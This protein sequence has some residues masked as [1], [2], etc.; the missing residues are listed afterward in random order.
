LFDVF[1]EF[2]DFLVVIFNVALVHKTMS[3]SYNVW[4]MV[5]VFFKSIFIFFFVCVYIF[6]AW[7]KWWTAK[8]FGFKNNPNNVEQAHY[9]EEDDHDHN[10]EMILN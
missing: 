5:M 10:F 3:E 4:M 8:R 6:Y 7:R 1:V 9:E 2:I